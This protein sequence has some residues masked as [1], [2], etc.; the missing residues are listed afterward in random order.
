LRRKWV[1]ARSDE[2]HV[3]GKDTDPNKVV[4]WIRNV[5]T[6]P[7]GLDGDME[8]LE[9]AHVRQVLLESWARGKRDLLGLSIVADGRGAVEKDGDSTRMVAKAITRAR[10]VDMVVHPAAGGRV[11]DLVAAEGV[12]PG[13]VAMF[14]RI[15]RFLEAEHPALHDKLRGD[16]DEKVHFEPLPELDSAQ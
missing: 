8:L 4:G 11:L 15:L 16:E 7:E 5:Q 12:C 2:N 14:D 9:S 3:E 10:S 1:L 13:G 6:V